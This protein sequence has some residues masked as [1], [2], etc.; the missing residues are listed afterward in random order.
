MLNQIMLIVLVRIKT[1]VKNQLILNAIPSG[2]HSNDIFNIKM[3]IGLNVAYFEYLNSHKVEHNFF[4][5][6][7]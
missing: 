7:I 3:P 1:F 5:K 2:F 4:V 6:N